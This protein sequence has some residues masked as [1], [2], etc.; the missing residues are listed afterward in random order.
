L[1][2]AAPKADAAAALCYRTKPVNI[3][4]FDPARSEGLRLQRALKDRGVPTTL[5]TEPSHCLA[6][7]SRVGEVDPKVGVVVFRAGVPRSVSVGKNLYETPVLGAAD[8]KMSGCV[9]GRRREIASGRSLHLGAGI[10]QHDALH[11]RRA[12]VARCEIRVGRIA[13][14]RL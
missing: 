13:K 14:Q 11:R 4:I 12:L 1:G 3:V 6:V 8:Q 10:V 7:V 2:G 5:A 9:R